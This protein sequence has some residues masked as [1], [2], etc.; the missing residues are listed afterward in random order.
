M[1]IHRK[2]EQA[3]RKNELKRLGI[4]IKN[5]WRIAV[6][7]TVMLAIS[8]YVLAAYG[9]TRHYI[10]RVSMYIES[11]DEMTAPEKAQ[12]VSLLF[13]SPKMYDAMNENLATK[14]SYAEF[15]KMIK[16]EPKNGTQ[17]IDA[18]FDCETPVDSY[19]LADLYMSKIG[20]VLE[21]YQA[22]A[23]VNVLA[24]PVEPQ[25]ADFPDEN[26][27]AAIGAAV[28]AVLSIAG[29]IV[30]WRLDNT[31]NSADNISEEYNVPIL[32]ELIDFD[33][34]IDYLGR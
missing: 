6:V 7:V 9:M 27:F 29:I 16:V 2:R 23:S 15:S 30:I 4:T 26:M 11:T 21:D 31:I 5:N 34:E 8:G 33:N 12:M 13:T 14:F 20:G 3:L 17:I 32:G 25:K 22:N 18:S 1:N 28:G 19:K 24:T 10:T